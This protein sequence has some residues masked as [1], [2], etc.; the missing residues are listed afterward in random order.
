[1][2]NECNVACIHCTS[3]HG[4]L[5]KRSCVCPQTTSRRLIPLFN[6]NSTAASDIRFP[7]QGLGWHRCHSSISSCFRPT[8]L[9]YLASMLPEPTP[10]GFS[11]IAVIGILWSLN[12]C[13]PW[14]LTCPGRRPQTTSALSVRNETNGAGPNPCNA[15][16]K[17]VVV[18]QLQSLTSFL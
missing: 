1:V 17:G 8:S 2:S 13:L 6:N 16:A 15:S 14:H 7:N 5:T 18:G 11:A 10:T 9:P 12:S 4:S 3:S